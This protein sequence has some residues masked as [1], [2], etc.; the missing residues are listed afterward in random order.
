MILT[1]AGTSGHTITDLS[2]TMDVRPLLSTDNV[3][4]VLNRI[5][6]ISSWLFKLHKTDD[7]MHCSVCIILNVLYACNNIF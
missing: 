5:Q 7:F 3:I 2:T 6:K 4:G 1:R